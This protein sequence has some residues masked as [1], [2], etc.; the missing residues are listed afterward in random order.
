MQTIYQTANENKDFDLVRRLN[1]E[2]L[3]PVIDMEAGP[4][5]LS[6]FMDIATKQDV[7][8]GFLKNL[9]ETHRLFTQTEFTSLNGPHWVKK[10]DITRISGAQFIKDK[11]NELGLKHIHVPHK[12]AVISEEEPLTMYLSQSSGYVHYDNEDIQIY[13][14]RIVSENRT[15]TREEI[16]ELIAIIQATNFSDLNPSNIVVAKDGIY[17]IDTELKSF[18]NNIM[19]GK[20][21]R[22]FSLIAE[23]DKEYFKQKVEEKKNTPTTPRLKSYVDLNDFPDPELLSR[24]KYVGMEK[25]GSSYWEPTTITFKNPTEL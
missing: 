1:A 2:G 9:R 13:A 4:S 7:L 17:F 20:L 3:A 21:G 12:I 22:F 10:R 14:K 16:D 19:W 18:E 15:L 23:E 24:Y 5:I 11:S 8:E 6:P 25:H